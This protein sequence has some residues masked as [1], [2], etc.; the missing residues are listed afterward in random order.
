[1]AYRVAQDLSAPLLCAL[2]LLCFSPKLACGCYL[3]TSSMLCFEVCSSCFIH[4][5]CFFP[6]V[7][8]FSAKFTHI[9]F[10]MTLIL[11]TSCDTATCRLP[12]HFFL[13][14]FVLHFPSFHII[15]PLRKLSIYLSSITFLPIYSSLSIHLSIIHPSSPQLKCQLFESED[16]CLV[17]SLMHPKCSEQGLAQEEIL[18]KYLLNEFP[19]KFEKMQRCL[20]LI[21][22]S[23]LIK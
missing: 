11:T 14:L 3:K 4:L 8:S 2:Y 19:F 9:I 5:E 13:F 15:H 1:M 16:L 22:L 12:L 21:I 6:G 10:L 7:P 17:C 18:H 23:M 20:I